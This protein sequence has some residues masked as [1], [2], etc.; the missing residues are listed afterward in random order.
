MRS[1]KYSLV[2]ASQT[3]QSFCLSV[4]YITVNFGEGVLTALT[5]QQFQDISLVPSCLADDQ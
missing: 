2:T 5:K 4:F 3:F 1:T